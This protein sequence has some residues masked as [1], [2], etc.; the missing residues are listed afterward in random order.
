MLYLIIRRKFKK[1]NFLS[2]LN[3]KQTK[4]YRM[5]G[6]ILALDR[7]NKCA[8]VQLLIGF[9]VDKFIDADKKAL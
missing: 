1:C 5:A 2:S 8:G 9:I 6:N 7:D 4:T 3:T